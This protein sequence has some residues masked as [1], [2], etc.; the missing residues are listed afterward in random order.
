V[1]A[2]ECGAWAWLLTPA[3]WSYTR[4]TNVSYDLATTTLTVAGGAGPTYSVT[5]AAYVR[6]D[7]ADPSYPY[8]GAEDATVVANFACDAGTVTLTDLDVVQSG[9]GGAWG[10]THSWGIDGTIT[11]SP[12]VP[13]WREGETAWSPTTTSTWDYYYTGYGLH[14]H[15]LESWAETWAFTVGADDSVALASGPTVATP[16]L[17]SWSGGSTNPWSLLFATQTWLDASA[18]VAWGFDPTQLYLRE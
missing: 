3:T 1:C 12:P 15:H 6:W 4:P 5:K 16:L 7:G 17:L 2:D 9:Y 14:T 18:P 8:I 10:S 13:V 11:F